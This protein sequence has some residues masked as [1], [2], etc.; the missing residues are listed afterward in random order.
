MEKGEMLLDSAREKLVTTYDPYAIYL[1]GESVWGSNSSAAGG[2][3]LNF[4]V[5]V[6]KSGEKVYKRPVKGMEA[7]KDLPLQTDVTVY[8]RREFEK[9]SCHMFTLCYKIKSE[10]KK[11]YIRSQ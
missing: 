1:Y 5:L 10:G 3:G 11:L 2:S 4:L 8:T 9:L 7:L 6:E